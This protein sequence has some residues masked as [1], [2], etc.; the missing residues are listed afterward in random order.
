MNIFLFLNFKITS[1]VAVLMASPVPDTQNDCTCDAD[2]TCSEDC[3]CNNCC[4]KCN[5]RND[6]TFDIDYP[7]NV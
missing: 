7:D 3:N 4:D 5:C 1:C 2:C 6:K